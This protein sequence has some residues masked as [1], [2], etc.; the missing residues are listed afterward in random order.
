M[1]VALGVHHPQM[2]M[3]RIL[4][5]Q[6][7]KGS[8]E[9][10]EAKSFIFTDGET[11]ACRGEVVYPTSHKGR[12]DTEWGTKALGHGG[13]HKSS[14]FSQGPCIG[15]GSEGNMGCVFLFFHTTF[16]SVMLGRLFQN[17]LI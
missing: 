9:I 13:T 17:P 7:R 2:L 14:S 16:I 4:E 6:S 15:G 5:C 12:R 10:I 3:T 11:E 1:R 8:Q